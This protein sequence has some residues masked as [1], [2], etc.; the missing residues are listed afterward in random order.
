M[1]GFWGEALLDALR[2][3]GRAC[4]GGGLRPIGVGGTGIA[5]SAAEHQVGEGT[6]CELALALDEACFLCEGVGV[7][8][9]DLSEGVLD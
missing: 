5:G 3:E 1:R 4:D 7:V 9:K 8:F 2:G 6:A